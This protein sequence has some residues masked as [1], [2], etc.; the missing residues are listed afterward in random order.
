MILT[1]SEYFFSHAML[2]I[3]K[4]SKIAH[5][6]ARSAGYLAFRFQFGMSVS[7]DRIF[8]LSIGAPPYGVKDSNSKKYIKVTLPLNHAK[9]VVLLLLVVLQMAIFLS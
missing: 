9:V 7:V 1:L 5:L 8:L 6:R 2:F 4:Y 3:N